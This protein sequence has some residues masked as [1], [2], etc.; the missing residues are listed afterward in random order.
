MALETDILTPASPS[1]AHSNPVTTIDLRSDTVTRPTA[2]MRA[3]M[4]EAEVG[5]DVYGEDPTVNALEARAA[6][7]FGR[8]AGLFVPTG[9]MGNQI[10]IRLHTERGQEVLCEARAHL[11]DWEMAMVADFNGCQ[12]RTAYAED[13]VFR[14]EHIKALIAPKI[15]YRQQPG[16]ISLENTHNMAGG[17][18]TPLPVFE[19]IWEGARE[20]GLPVHL[21]GARIF[22]AATHLGIG[23]QELTSGFDSVMFCLSKGLCAPVGSMLVG[24]GEFI[25]R[26]RSVRKALGGGMRQAGILAAAGLIAL[27]EMP[28][29][30]HE[31]HS[32]ARILAERL[33]A[34]PGVELDLHSVQSNIVIFYLRG[35]RD[36]NHVVRALKDR[37]V[38]AGAVGPHAVRFV[39]H[40]DVDRSAC[41]H[42]ARIAAEVLA[43]A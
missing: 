31:D 3:V 34:L 15:Y 17:I 29:R 25:A 42:A 28:A 36:A 30:L 39:T 19:E 20:A 7:V 8:E 1:F 26:A 40:H 6:E 13:G 14:W 2:R 5:D 4:A 12:L 22:H 10:A 23:V 32:N 24:S 41:A 21:D 18:V 16:L 27:D 11:I 38:L 35:G 33:A 37:G 43:E 9:T